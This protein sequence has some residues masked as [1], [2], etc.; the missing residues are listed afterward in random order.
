MGA[1]YKPISK[2]SRQ[3]YLRRPNGSFKARIATPVWRVP[4]EKA[5]WKA[6]GR[7][8]Y[9]SRP[10]ARRRQ[11]FSLIKKLARRSC[12]F[13]IGSSIAVR[14]SHI[15]LVQTTYPVGVSRPTSAAASV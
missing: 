12:K 2:R 7:K 15:V 11:R 13:E 9:R 4:S 8:K 14:Q 3:N 6:T 10:A 1:H 5:N